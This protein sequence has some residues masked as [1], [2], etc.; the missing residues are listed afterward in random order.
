MWGFPGSASHR[1][2]S[3]HCVYSDEVIQ[4]GTMVLTNRTALQGS[5]KGDKILLG[6][7]EVMKKGIHPG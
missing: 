5:S 3:G 4:Q 6:T 2:G 1:S 7:R